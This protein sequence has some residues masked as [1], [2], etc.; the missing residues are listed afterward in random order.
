METTLHDPDRYML[1]LRQILAQGRKNIGFLL[2]AGSPASIRIDKNTGKISKEG[3]SLIPT[4]DDLTKTV[5]DKLEKKDTKIIE[6]VCQDL[7][8][9]PNIEKILSRTRSLSKIIGDN[10]FCGYDGEYFSRLSEQICCQIGEVVGA[11]LPDENNPYQELTSWIGGINRSNP[12]EIFTP[13]YDL[14]T[15]ESLESR[16]IPYFDGFTGSV[17]PFFDPVSIAN[18]DLPSRWVRLWKLHGSLG[19]E[20]NKKGRIYRGKGRDATNLIYPDHLKYDQI[21]KLPFIALFDRLRKFLTTPDT[22][23]MA[24]GF[25]FSDAHIVAVIDE[26]LAANPAASLFAFQYN[27]LDNEKA[28]SALALKRQNMSVFAR[29]GAIINCIPGSWSLGELCQRDLKFIRASYWGKNDSDIEDTDHYLLGDFTSFARFVALTN[30]EKMDISAS[31]N[32]EASK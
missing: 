16:D 26:A 30:V 24:C 3:A 21:Q 4:I 20:I 13:N 18:N 15:E 23:L 28:A 22:L 9:N 6:Q 19:W 17:E 2:G 7:E 8:S 31:I 14:L 29:D 11:S 27:L 32:E 5:L 12:I 25:S 1:D 10:P